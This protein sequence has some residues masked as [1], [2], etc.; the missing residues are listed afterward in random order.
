MSTPLPFESQIRLKQTASGASIKTIKPCA[1]L[2]P[3]SK[4]TRV[5]GC[6]KLAA[7]EIQYSTQIKTGDPS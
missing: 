4:I 3:G 5:L 7:K 2:P 6:T 1:E